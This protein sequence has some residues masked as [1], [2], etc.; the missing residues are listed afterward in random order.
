MG[1][2]VPQILQ[3]L[4]CLGVDAAFL[5]KGLPTFLS[6]NRRL[7][8]NMFLVFSPKS[9]GGNSGPPRSFSIILVFTCPRPQVP[10]NEGGSFVWGHRHARI[11]CHIFL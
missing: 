4:H 1:C 6:S 3:V 8:E 7:K 11:F 10:E 5:N 9:K 2:I